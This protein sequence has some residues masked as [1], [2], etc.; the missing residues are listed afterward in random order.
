VGERVLSRVLVELTGALVDG[1][2]LVDW[3]HVLLNHCTAQVGADRIAAVVVTEGAGLSVIA[4]TNE[5]A[6]CLGEMQSLTR[7]G[8]SF[9]CVRSR[10][11]VESVDLRSAGDRWPRFGPQAVAAG[12]PVVSAWPMMSGDVVMGALT[13][14]HADARDLS[15]D[16]VG[17]ATAMADLAA[18]GV[19]HGPRLRQQQTQVEQLQTALESRVVIEQAKG[20]LVG[21]YQ[22]APPQAFELLRKHAR[23]NGLRLHDVARDVVTS[24]VEL[25]V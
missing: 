12:F 17:A 15:E 1:P 19:C 14:V 4:A 18:I 2:E 16:E 23:N 5:R 20:V 21:R 7:E 13:M 24:T 10:E 22:I 8:P 11:A 6:R 3:L 25:D 9:D